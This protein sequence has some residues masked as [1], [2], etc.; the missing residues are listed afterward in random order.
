MNQ[1]S[2][3]VTIEGYV[4]NA[5]LLEKLLTKDDEF[6]KAYRKLIR[7]VLQSA[8][9]R[10]GSNVRYGIGISKD[11]R[12]AYKAVKM[13]VYKSIFGGNVSILNRKRSGNIKTSYHPP[14]TLRVSRRGGNR[15]PISARTL[16]VNSYYGLDRAFILRWLEEGTYKTPRRQAG[17]HGGNLHGNRGKIDAKHIFSDNASKELEMAINEIAESFAE[18][19]NTV[20]NGQ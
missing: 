10:I 16:A 7:K 13:A 11:P 4:E 15:V 14:R 5:Q 12:D 9:R 1:G 19:I 6:A 2:N 3:T 20:I 17:T 18:Y 8:R